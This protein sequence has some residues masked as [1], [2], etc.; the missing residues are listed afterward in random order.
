M[1]NRGFWRELKRRHVY[2]VAAAYAI[3]GWLL[4]QVATQVFP[5][6][7]LPD[8]IDQAVVLLILVGFPI[9]LVL[10][11]AFDATPHGIV[12][13][14]A[15][16]NA[17]V[18]TARRSRRA[19]IAVGL[20]GVLIAVLAGGVW[21]QT[22]RTGAE[23]D[24][25]VAST[26]RMPDKSG[27]TTKVASASTAVPPIAAQPIPAKSIAVL[28]LTNES[29]DKDQQYFS[30]GLSEN[31]ITALSQFP[32][33]KV[34]SRDS[35][36]RFRNSNDSSATIG[37]RLGVAHLLEGSV[38]RAGSEVRISVELVNAADG[39]TLWSHAYD[40]PYQDLFALQDAITKAVALALKARLLDAGGAVTQSDRPPS[41][42]LG[43][44][45]AYLQGRFYDQRGSETAL[46]QAIAKYAEAAHLDPDYAAAYAS[47][48]RTLT[49]LAGF[50]LGGA[51]IPGAYAQARTL[52]NTALRLDPDLAEAHLSNA[53]LIINADLDWSG[54]GPE[55]RRAIELAPG[56]PEAFFSLSTTQA[57][58][59]HVESALGSIQQA[60]AKNP[61][62]AFWHDW[63]ASY[64]GAL[65]R[66][67]AAEA[68][69]RHS[70]NLEPQETL[71]CRDL[72]F[73]EV[74]RG[75]ATAAL[76]AA[77]QTPPGRNHDI[78]V[79]WALQIGSNRKAADAALQSLIARHA[80]DSSYQ[81]ADA[82]ALR[83]DPDSVFKWLDQAWANRDNG[84][85]YLTYD[86]LILRYRH[87]PRFAAFC[88]KVG[89]PTTTDAKALP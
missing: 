41:G 4:I 61:L 89:L 26:Q 70:I 65:G 42:S 60:L 14:D 87:D 51:E 53:A 47:E 64:L 8:W 7:H 44:Y 78:A 57:F 33:L 16:D 82:Y 48:A 21:W 55:I 2:R 3:V 6:F 40:R 83:R 85:Q 46:R 74:L 22:E 76:D 56:D 19:G 30:D 62:S 34:I 39:S 68:A 81:I 1:A 54:A 11:W 32:G 75:N 13:T 17:D 52:T 67:D 86:P 18:Q 77:Q 58:S 10:A 66:F 73:I 49:R 71:G 20:I 12:R 63:Q 37:S 25:P 79:A 5:V 36:F 59:G 27:A 43:A 35:S 80:G 69:A 50:Y 15:Q 45:N 72:T 24:A 84:I 28:P 31:L 9:A 38:Q 23:R 88:K 29:R